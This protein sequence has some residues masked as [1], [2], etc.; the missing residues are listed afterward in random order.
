MW[1]R[2]VYTKGISFDLYLFLSADSWRK[3]VKIS[4]ENHFYVVLIMG[5]IIV[6]QK[7]ET[8]CRL[9]W[10]LFRVSRWVGFGVHRC[11]CQL[12][13]RLRRFLHHLSFSQPKI[14][15]ECLPK[16]SS[17]H[18]E[19]DYWPLFDCLFEAKI[20]N[21]QLRFN[22]G[23]FVCLFV[24]LSVWFFCHAQFVDLCN[25]FF[26]LVALTELICFPM[27]WSLNCFVSCLSPMTAEV[28]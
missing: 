24:C 26:P 8:A 21:M 12:L 19:L 15:I 1:S 5:L 17:D 11:Y 28:I 22:C 27:I 6:L 4:L 20:K 9:A 23:L 10:V 14:L 16:N 3:C 13:E 2:K 7:L 25:M 18:L